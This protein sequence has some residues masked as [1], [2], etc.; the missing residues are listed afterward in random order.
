[1][2]ESVDEHG[3]NAAAAQITTAGIRSEIDDETHAGTV[4]AGPGSG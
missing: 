4:E 3:L 2:L 1:M